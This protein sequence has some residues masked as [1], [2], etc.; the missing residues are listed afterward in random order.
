MKRAALALLLSTSLVHADAAAP[1]QDVLI[2]EGLR[3]L[4]YLDYAGAKDRFRALQER[5]PEDPLGD[6]AAATAL[7]WELTN[8]FDESNPALEKE[9]LTAADRAAESARARIASAGDPDGNAHLCLG[10][11]LGLTARWE[12]IGG[13]WLAA[14]RH[15]RQAFKAQEEAI[16]LNPK[17]YDAY[18]GVGIFHYYTATL[19]AV[20]KVL[21]KMMFGGN[22]QQGL[23][24][25]RT[26]MEKGRF[27]RTAARLF[28]VGLLVN[29]EK[30]PEEALAL[31]REGRR[32]HEGSPFFHLIEMMV[33]EEAKKWD[34]LEAQ[35]K[36]FLAKVDRG[37]PFY[38]KKYAHRALFCLGNAALGRGRPE[39]AVPIYDR[40]L[41]EHKTE[42]R[43]VTWTLLN[44]GR[45]H[46]R[47]LE[48]EAA[49]EDYRAVLARRNV[50]GF[51]ERAKGHLKEPDKA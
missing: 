44:R 26:A 43:W 41:A 39:D 15:G 2:E 9:F 36:D 16:R 1:S 25:I 34:E 6:Y 31:V 22:K 45:A 27:S 7:W 38:D 49:K 5:F 37:E 8:E 40:V 14:Y 48:R 17:M 20:V 10:G 28:M 51:H 13:E 18:L 3:A 33:L 47:L 21:A 11:A 32:Q 23:D 46:D 4:Y 29:T 35:A 19:P 50:W 24:E 30:K 42:D 12:A